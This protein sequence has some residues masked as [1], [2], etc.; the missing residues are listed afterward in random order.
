MEQRKIYLGADH[1]GFPLKEK[2]K[3]WM[4]NNYIA[5]E[6]LGN[7]TLEPTDDYPDYAEKVARRVI[8]DNT[9]GILLCGS[10]QG[11]CVAAN[12][13]KGIRAVT[14][15][16]IKEA[17]L[18]R[19]HL[20]ANVICI[21]EMFIH[22]HLAKQ[23]IKSFLTTPFSEAPRHVRRLNKIYKIESAK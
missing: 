21:A 9:F 6:D 13:V 4:E 17:R 5:Y 12:K 22:F 2:L 10:A 15:S 11:V 3:R 8:K 14:P 23:M 19:E 20:D 7:L 1:R 18:A 16:N